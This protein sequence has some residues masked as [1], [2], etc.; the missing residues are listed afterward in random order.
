MDKSYGQER[1]E[2]V[3]THSEALTLLMVLSQESK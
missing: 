3:D 1:T 2:H